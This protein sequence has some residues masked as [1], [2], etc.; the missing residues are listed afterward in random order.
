[1]NKSKWKKSFIIK[2]KNKYIEKIF[3]FLNGDEKP[4]QEKKKKEKKR[5]EIK[6]K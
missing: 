1:M 6:I 4:Y 3:Q 2:K 5:K